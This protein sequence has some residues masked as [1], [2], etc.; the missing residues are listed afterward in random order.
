MPPDVEPLLEALTNAYGPSGFEGPVRALV[1]RELAPIADSIETDGLGSLIARLDGTSDAPRVMVTAHMDELGLMVRRV[2]DEGFIKFQPLGGWLDQA[3]INQ[4][5]V[6]LAREGPVP[7]V[8]GIKT[9]HVMKEDARKKVFERDEM[10]ID[11]GA[12]S[13]ADA[14]E[15]LAIHPGDPIVPDS[16]FTVLSGGAL[17]LAKAWDDRVGLGVIIQVLAALRDGQPPPNRVFAV[18]TVQE[19]VGLRGA[20]TS[21]YQ[22]KPDIGISIEA[23]VAGDYPGISPDEAQEQ[24]GRGPSMFLHDS[25]MMPNLHLRDFVADVAD[26]AGIPLQF[27][28]LTGYGQDGSAIQRSRTGAPVINIAVPTRYLH[29]HNGIISRDDFMHTVR[30]VTEIVRRLDASAVERIRSFD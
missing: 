16:R 1:R 3:L 18:A 7:G 12:T 26:D 4:R 5:W 21:S 29:S 15:R 28:V 8:T 22:V 20:Q 13:R 14:E 23:G 17:Y 25:S 9:V 6:V 2:T 30:L 19:E 10:F 11:V 24:I 27:S